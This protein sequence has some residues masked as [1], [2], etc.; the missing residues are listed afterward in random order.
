MNETYRLWPLAVVAAVGW[1][2]YQ[3]SPILTPFVTSAALAYLGDPL[4]DRLERLGVRRGLATATVFFMILL[5]LTAFVFLLIPLLRQQV[6]ALVNAVP[7]YIDWFYAKAWP[8]LQQNLELRA[9]DLSDQAQV[10]ALAREYL[11]SS[12]AALARTVGSLSQ[13]GLAVLGWVL[14]GLLV[15]VITFYFLRDWD[16][17]MRQVY[18]LVPRRYAP[19][20][21]ALA[22]EAD[23]V[24]SGFV[25]GQFIV[26]L[27]LA[28]LYSLG[29]WL[30]GLEFPL[31]IGLI[32]GL[33]GFIPYLGLFVG[34]VLAGL[35][36]LVQFQ[37]PG[38]LLGVLAVF[39]VVQVLEGNWL[40]PKIVGEK[41][42]LHP[43]AVIFAVLAGGQLFGFIG[44]LL[45]L[46]A[47]AVLMVLL[48]HTHDAYR[49]SVFYGASPEAEDFLDRDDIP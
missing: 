21:L 49:K 15:P 2:L 37:S 44:L 42:G 13:Q 10:K 32:A 8:W 38:P 22:V 18:E 47:A 34:L 11:Q 17:M 45:A 46:P 12:G 20:V 23:E 43:V 48:R 16:R 29:L 3:L 1:L 30:V 39:V 33:L 27:V 19:R 25:R 6:G 4:T 41:I 14:N 24:L 7:G 9:F 35:S 40:T 5:S 31:V 26:M 28:G 36:A